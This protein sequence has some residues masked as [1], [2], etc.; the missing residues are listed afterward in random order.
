[1]CVTI[2]HSNQT[3]S[4]NVI[5]LLSLV[6]TNN[7]LGGGVWGIYKRS[8]RAEGESQISIKAP[9]TALRTTIIHVHATIETII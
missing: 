2:L 5:E 3:M 1:M 7:Y 4:N 6:C 8:T 9:K